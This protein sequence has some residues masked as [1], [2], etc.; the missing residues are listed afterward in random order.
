MQE[1]KKVKCSN[2]PLTYDA[3]DGAANPNNIKPKNF[4][5]HTNAPGSDLRMW[6]R[7]E[8]SDRKKHTLTRMQIWNRG[9]NKQLEGLHE[10][11]IC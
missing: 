1:S 11:T 2:F 7:I 8:F 9:D 5:S 3:V 4:C 6:W 10:A